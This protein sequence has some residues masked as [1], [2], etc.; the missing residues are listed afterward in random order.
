[1]VGKVALAEVIDLGTFFSLAKVNGNN[2]FDLSTKAI[3]VGL[4]YHYHLV[5]LITWFFHQL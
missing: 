1:M 5:S 2:G 4:L 3:F